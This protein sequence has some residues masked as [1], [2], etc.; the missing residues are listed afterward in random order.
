MASEDGE[1][2]ENDACTCEDGET[3]GHAAKTYTNWIV[4]VDIEGLSGPEEEDREEVCAGNEGDD[5]GESEDARIFLQSV[6]EHG[7]FCT[8]NF[9]EGESDE[10]G[11]SK[12]KGGEGVDGFPGILDKMLDWI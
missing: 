10:E 3:D 1:E 4:A 11:S 5:Q 9:P 8:I 2:P 12:E 6:R 7:P